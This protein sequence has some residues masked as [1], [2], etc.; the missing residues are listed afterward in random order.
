MPKAMAKV[1]GEAPLLGG[2]YHLLAVVA[3]VAAVVAVE[4]GEA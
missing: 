1:G 4:A 2:D 3:A